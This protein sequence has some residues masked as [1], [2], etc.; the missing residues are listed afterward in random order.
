MKSLEELNTL[1]IKSVAKYYICPNNRIEL[2]E[3]LKFAKDKGV[4]LFILGNGSN[5]I[6]SKDFYQDVLFLNTKGLK[7]ILLNDGTLFC[8]AGVLGKDLINFSIK[9]GLSGFE[10]LTGIPGTV[11]GFVKMNSGAFG[12][13]M[14]D[15]VKSVDV[16]DLY[17]FNY[18]QIDAK[19]I[20]FE[21]RGALNLKSFIILGAKLSFKCEDPSLIKMRVADIA[22]S[23]AL[24]QPLLN[25]CGSVFKNGKGY[26][27]GKLIEDAG[28][29][30]FSIGGASVSKKHANFII[31]RGDAVGSD[32][33]KLINYIQEKIFT[34]F[35]V[36][37]ERE[38][39]IF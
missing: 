24:K 17:T 6:F 2:I 13:E 1:K 23:R 3:A 12:K 25:N 33:V 14:K 37:L 7:K 29:K 30:G 10:F 4:K 18:D 16:I 19:Y 8:E 11:G 38:V 32:V 15:I 5:L 20:L 21:Y 9:N 36:K 35:K 39:Y 31:N 28:L 26:F 27:A 34:I 22:K